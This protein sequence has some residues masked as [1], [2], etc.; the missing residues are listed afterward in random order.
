M[1][2]NEIKQKIKSII[3]FSEINEFIEMPIKYYSSGMYLRLAFSVAIHSDPDIYLFDEIIT[4]GD[5]N[6]K[7]KC[8][9]KIA[10]L[11]QSKKTILFVSHNQELLEKLTDKIFY[12][13]NGIFTHEGIVEK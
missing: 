7:Q 13:E 6:F 11:R 4:V 10:E 8:L 3:D 5:Q 9:Q 1:K 12:I 2:I